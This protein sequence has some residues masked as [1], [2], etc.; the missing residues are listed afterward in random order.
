MRI[1]TQDEIEYFSWLSSKVDS[2]RE[3][4]YVFLFK[5]MHRKS[6]YS[7][8]PMDENRFEDGKFL[9]KRFIDEK[10]LE[11]SEDFIGPCSFLEFLVALSM[12]IQ[13]IDDFEHDVD[14]YFWILLR[15]I[16]LD[17]M[18]NPTFI[19]QSVIDIFESSV[20]RVLDRTY[21]RNGVGG[22]FPLKG[23]CKDQRKIE[24]WIQMNQYILER[25]NFT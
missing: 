13:E 17:Q 6:C 8:V 25:G 14:Y 7:I 11:A 9:R 20:N 1:E 2:E 15:N 18:D 3:S 12:K 4:N 16:G 10:K 23:R 19:N 5:A 24:I 21:K 22:L